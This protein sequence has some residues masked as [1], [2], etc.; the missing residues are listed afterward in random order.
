MVFVRFAWKKDGKINRVFFVL[1]VFF[2]KHFSQKGISS[3]GGEYEGES[4]AGKT[5]G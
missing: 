4:L 3:G 1:S 2:G 5:G